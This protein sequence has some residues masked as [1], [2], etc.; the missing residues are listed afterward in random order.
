M[1]VKINQKDSVFKLNPELRSVPEFDCLTEKQM[2][3]IALVFDY[4]SPFRQK[5]QTDRWK[6]AFL[7]AGYAP[8]ETK[9][10][11]FSMRCREMMDGKHPKVNAAIKKYLSIQRDED[12]ELLNDLQTHLENIKSMMR[13]GRE[14]PAELDKINKLVMSLPD[15]RE[16]QRK[17]AAAAHIDYSFGEQEEDDAQ[18]NMSTIDKMVMDES[19]EV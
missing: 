17:I 15:L 16:T 12:M 2:R 11:V 8:E 6:L 1:L 13:K 4:K 5:T 10:K 9:D 14:D 3:V 7:A 19:Q 18:K